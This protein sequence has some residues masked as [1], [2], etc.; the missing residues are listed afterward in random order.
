[1]KLHVAERRERIQRRESNCTTL[2]PHHHSFPPPLGK[3]LRKVSNCACGELC[4]AHTIF[5][6]RITT[7][8]HVPQHRLPH[9]EE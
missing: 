1:M 2:M 5:R 6:R 4:G 9:I 7:L 3:T 8:L